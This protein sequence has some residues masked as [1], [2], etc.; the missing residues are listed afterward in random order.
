MK[1]LA[2]VLVCCATA[3]A[4]FPTARDTA[5][6]V[7]AN[8]T[9]TRTATTTTRLVPRDADS[10]SITFDVTHTYDRRT[11]ELLETDFSWS[12]PD[13]QRTTYIRETLPPVFPNPPEVIVTP[14][15]ETLRILAWEATAVPTSGTFG[16]EWNDLH[17]GWLFTIEATE[18]AGTVTFER[19]LQGPTSTVVSVLDVPAAAAVTALQHRFEEGG[20]QPLDDYVAGNFDFEGPWIPA[21]TV[22][23]LT[24]PAYF[25]TDALPIM[26]P[27]PA[28]A[29]PEPSGWTVLMLVGFLLA[30]AYRRRNRRD[31]Y[32]DDERTRFY[33][34]LYDLP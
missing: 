19:T 32:K 8:P 34:K 6:D 20:W 3:A 14:I 13:Y 25:L 18:S 11:L 7:L 31:D 21:A 1:T 27:P 9:F 30:W 12:V 23:G 28:V 16:P 26:A 29:V 2:F 15:E 5:L 10:P 24:V 4:S 33:A 22:D 17:R